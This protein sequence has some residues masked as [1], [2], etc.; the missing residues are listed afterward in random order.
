MK[1]PKPT[2]ADKAFFESIVPPNAEIKPMFGNL[3]GFVNG[4]MFMGLFG[5]DV[6]VRLK[7]DDRVLLEAVD[8]SG[9]FGPEDRPMKEY[10][11][12]PAAWRDDPIQ[13]EEWAGRAYDYVA[14]M[15]PK[16]KKSKK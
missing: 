14:A 6:G 8:G 2:D 15:P 12:L 1:I 9:P 5:P 7:P 11:A 3:G 4:N 10:L 13:A 16:V